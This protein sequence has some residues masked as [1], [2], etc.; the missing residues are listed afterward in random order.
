MVR[1][2]HDSVLW[3]LWGG[4]LL[5]LG[6][7]LVVD[8]LIKRRIPVPV[9]P[10][11]FTAWF[12]RGSARI[13]R[14]LWRALALTAFALSGIGMSA[15]G[16]IASSVSPPSHTPTT[17][18][19]VID[20]SLSMC[21]DDYSPYRLHVAS[22]WAEVLVRHA[23]NQGLLTR[24]IAFSSYPRPLA[25]FDRQAWLHSSTDWESVQV[26]SGT[27]IG[28]ALALITQ[29][30]AHTQKWIVLI[31]DGDNNVPPDPYEVLAH[32]TQHGARALIV[33]MQDKRSAKQ[34]RCT[35]NQLQT[36]REQFGETALS[37]GF[38]Q[39]FMPALPK[40]VE[41]AQRLPGIS[42]LVTSAQPTQQTSQAMIAWLHQALKDW[43]TEDEARATD[44]PLFNM[45]QARIVENLVWVMAIA[46]CL[47]FVAL[48]LRYG[49][50]LAFPAA[51]D[52]RARSPLEQ[53]GSQGP[54]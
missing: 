35:P 5:L 6:I 40:W 44:M 13:A 36:L 34:N 43:E 45:R 11:S 8:K 26:G 18:Y 37:F 31:T 46:A 28:G 20:T 53:Y 14:N 22:H 51:R 2:E 15:L 54:S 24:L 25:A 41:Q 3:W 10:F 7:L 39:P 32:L 52:P 29:D 12:P 33:V 17:L 27:A 23:H 42:V 48:S 19:L 16:M 1:A 9:L 30:S 38:Q 50:G 49:F 47:L 21:A 4:G